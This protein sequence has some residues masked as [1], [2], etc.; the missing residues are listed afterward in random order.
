MSF[1]DKNENFIRI[2]FLS[3][4][5][6]MSLEQK[7][8]HYNTY[9]KNETII[10]LKKHLKS[11]EKINENNNI[12]DC[13]LFTSFQNDLEFKANDYREIID[14]FKYF[15][16]ESILYTIYF[17]DYNTQ[18]FS[19]LGDE[20]IKNKPNDFI[21]K[22][23]ILDS[24]K[25]KE[26]LSKI[27]LSEKLNLTSSDWLEESDNRNPVV[28]KLIEWIGLKLTENNTE[29]EIK[30]ILF[31]YTKFWKTKYSNPYNEIKGVVL[32]NDL[33]STLKKELQD[34]KIDFKKVLDELYVLF[35]S[36]F[37]TFNL[38]PFLENESNIRISKMQGYNIK[39]N[40]FNLILN[41]SSKFLINYETLTNK[42]LFNLYFE[43]NLKLQIIIFKILKS[44]LSN[45][46]IHNENEIEY[47]KEIYLSKNNDSQQLIDYFIKTNYLFNLID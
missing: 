18:L 46:S 36:L 30:I 25:K 41:E 3:D 24:I 23:L 21:D 17:E 47:F 34:L 2:K 14:L 43:S 13:D 8:I 5:K 28:K 37:I 45:S 12:E 9:L 15:E 19:I 29:S 42:E 38:P 27:I 11:S 10:R 20:I 33:T 35:N 4:M 22:F 26:N 40:E 16:F 7:I 39:K 6:G 1:I 32:L 44:K 31:H